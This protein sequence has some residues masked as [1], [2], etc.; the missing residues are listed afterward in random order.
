M[1]S[2]RLPPSAGGG[3]EDAGG[4]E[5]GGEAGDECEL[6][7][8]E[9]P[10]SDHLAGEQVA[11]PRRREDQLDDAVVLLLDDAGDHPLAVD[12][13]RH[14]QEQ[15]ADV[16]DQ[17]LG[18]GGLLLGGMERCRRQLRCRRQVVA[19]RAHG[20]VCDR[21]G[22]RIDVRAEDEPVVA[23]GA[24]ARRP[25]W[26]RAPAVRPLPRRRRA[27][28]PSRCRTVLPRVGAQEEGRA[29]PARSLRPGRSASSRGPV[30]GRRPADDEEQHERRDEEHLA[31]Q[32]LAD[33][34]PGDERDRAP[35]A[36]GATSSRNS[37]ASVGGP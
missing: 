17:G 10:D 11:R 7:E 26:L 6:R 3:V 30:Q 9:Q 28:A 2:A 1:T 13:E 4:E 21:R 32:A 20:R 35:A 23:T 33:L 25:A 19:E 37:S 31:A 16:R 8:S 5:G 22:L 34:A 12:R 27:A 24:G 36:H 15:G 18:V 29:A 14:Q